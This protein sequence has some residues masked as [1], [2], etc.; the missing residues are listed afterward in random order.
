MKKVKE[1]KNEGVDKDQ[2]VI[3]YIDEYLKSLP[4]IKD[5]IIFE[6]DIILKQESEMYI[7]KSNEYM[8]K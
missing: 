4:N 5:K 6:R 3:E 2:L 1:S 8:E 7:E